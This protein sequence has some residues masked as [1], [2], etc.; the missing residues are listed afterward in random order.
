[1][2]GDAMKEL[3]KTFWVAPV[4]VAMMIF[5]TPFAHANPKTV[6]GMT[7]RGKVVEKKNIAAM[8]YDVGPDC[9]LLVRVTRVRPF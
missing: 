7:C 2:C 6:I 1:M 3:M 9:F 8:A 4:V 5:A